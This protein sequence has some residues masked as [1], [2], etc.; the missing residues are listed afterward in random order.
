MNPAGS[1][2]PLSLLKE[3]N[4]KIREQVLYACLYLFGYIPDG[5]MKTKV[6]RN[7]AYHTPLS[8]SYRFS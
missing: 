3:E 6:N 4:K 8:G 2:K 1:G 7:N 5:L